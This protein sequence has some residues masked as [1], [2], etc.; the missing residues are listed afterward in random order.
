LDSSLAQVVSACTLI[1][2]IANIVK[3]SADAFRDVAVDLLPQIAEARDRMKEESVHFGQAAQAF[4]EEEKG[5]LAKRLARVTSDY[6]K[7]GEALTKELKAAQSALNAVEE[8]SSRSASDVGKALETV[9]TIGARVSQDAEN[10]SGTLRAATH[11]QTKELSDFSVELSEF[12]RTSHAQLLDAMD[13][14]IAERDSRVRQEVVERSN[15]MDR[16]M[17][18]I[19]RWLFLGVGTLGVLFLL[20]IAALL[21]PN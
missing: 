20:Q 6:A 9:Q 2:G 13:R 14:Q 12:F 3:T 5:Q 4:R 1:Q 7:L 19:E 15:Q 8:N 10:W 21:T 17:S 11:A 18:R 16:R